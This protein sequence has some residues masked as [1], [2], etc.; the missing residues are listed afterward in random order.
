LHFRRAR[1]FVDASTANFKTVSCSPGL[2]DRQ[3]KDRRAQGLHRR[4]IDVDGISI[5]P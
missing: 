1:K 3:R 4:H 5:H 2:G